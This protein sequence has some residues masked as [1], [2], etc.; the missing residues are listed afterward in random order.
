MN[1]NHHQ[2]RRRN[3]NSF[4]ETKVIRKLVWQ[5]VIL[6]ASAGCSST[7]VVSAKAPSSS[8]ELADPDK[9]FRHH[10]LTIIGYNYT[11]YGFYSYQVDGRGG[12]NLE[13]STP[14]AGGSKSSCCFSLYTP[15]SNS[16]KVKVKWS[17]GIPQGLWCELEVP[18]KGPLPAKPEY[19][20][21]HFY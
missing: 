16:R 9:T 4:S 20:E 3:S 10:G 7:D 5:C 2:T 15:M 17:R 18:L 13:P 14:I 6:I 12:G 8:Y 1:T 11:D 21:V 19:L